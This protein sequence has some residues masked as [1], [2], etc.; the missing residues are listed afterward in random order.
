MP[1][2]AKG[3]IPFGSGSST[4][5]TAGTGGV[6][7]LACW[8]LL[9]AGFASVILADFAAWSSPF[10]D[11]RLMPLFEMR[12]RI[13][14]YTDPNR[15]P[16]LSTL[17]PPLSVLL[18]APV[19]LF[20]SPAGFFLA[21]LLAQIFTLSP[22]LFLLRLSVAEPRR[23]RA[24]HMLVVS[25]GFILWCNFSDIMSTLWLVH[26]D[27][28]AL[29]LTAVGL[30]F[31]IAFT[32]SGRRRELILAAVFASLAPWAKQTVI[33]VV[34]ILPV[35][36]ALR[37]EWRSFGLYALVAAASESVCLFVAA[38][39]F[40]F[41][42]LF[43]W[44]I[45][46]PA[47]HPWT[48]VWSTA[49]DDANRILLRE[50][51]VALTILAAMVVVEARAP[52]PGQRLRY[53]LS[54]PWVIFGMA[55]LFL[56]PVSMLGYVKIGG[57]NNTLLFSTYF[58]D[59]AV[60]A[61]L[62]ET[63]QNAPLNPGG[64]RAVRVVVAVFLALLSVRAAIT[65]AKS[66]L[67]P[68]RFAASGNADAYAVSLRH[69]GMVYFPWHPLSVYLA[70]GRLYHFEL[71]I[72]DRIAAGIE[73]DPENFAAHVPRKMRYVAY[74][75]TVPACALRFL[76]DFTKVVDFPELPPGWVVLARPGTA[77]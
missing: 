67:R 4:H 34:L 64:M 74:K 5:H 47:R 12:D 28:P 35:C 2:G 33:P 54:R 77:R 55:G 31:F 17:Y 27:A 21:G 18:Y 49:L 39:A 60:A 46:I 10:T 29:C 53:L 9:V 36:L 69:P 38:R 44:L 65:A 14:V 72:C 6:R 19:A 66:V 24:F 37:R 15:G 41:K 25:A 43:E 57:A 59:C 11:H 22:L 13:P 56:W 58:F 71:G 20:H 1:K 61:L 75:G 68:K 40:G 23:N 42:E 76:P 8:W 7:R 62:F 16:M 70:E 26:A 73:I 51:A 3:E 63:L 48:T 50:N 30:L 45:L 52:E 32:R